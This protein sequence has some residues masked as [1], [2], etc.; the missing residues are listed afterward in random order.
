[1]Y[2]TLL[3]VFFRSF[4]GRIEDTKRHFEIKCFWWL[5]SARLKYKPDYKSC[6]LLLINLANFPRYST[7]LEIL[8]ARKTLKSVK[9]E[10]LKFR[11]KG[12]LISECLF[13]IFNSSKK[14]TKKFDLTTLRCQINE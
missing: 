3:P 1:M 4:F 9:K 6:D 14:R 12:Q 10:L 8:F 13:G 5:S 7:S 11:A 2:L